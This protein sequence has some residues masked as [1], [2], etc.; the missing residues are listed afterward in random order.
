ME[1]CRLLQKTKDFKKRINMDFMTI[2]QASEKW[3]ICIRRVQTLCTEGRIEGAERLGHQWL[4]PITSEKPKDARIKSGKYI[5]TK[6]GNGE[7][8]DEKKT[9]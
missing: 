8:K 9:I 6:S 3:G 2:K 5:K 7:S 1:N 4:I